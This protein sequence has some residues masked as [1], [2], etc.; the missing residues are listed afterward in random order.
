MT[1]RYR[2]TP[3]LLLLVITSVEARPKDYLKRPDA[4]FAGEEAERMGTNILSYQ[5]ELGGW[6]K[7]VETT[8]G[9][10]S[11][12]RKKLKPTYDN[13]ATTDELRFLARLYNVTKNKTYR[14]AFDRGLNYVL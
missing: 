12:D 1:Y 2:L 4:W 14:D 6:P 10:Y 8:A 5:S 9:P 3:V 13:R 11:G 7:N